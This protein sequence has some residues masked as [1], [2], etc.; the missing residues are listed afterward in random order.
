M[1]VWDNIKKFLNLTPRQAALGSTFYPSNN[2][3]GRLTPYI[4]ADNKTRYIEDFEKGKY[5]YTV[6]SWIA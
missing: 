6:I 3:V 4:G 2:I 5:A 1:A